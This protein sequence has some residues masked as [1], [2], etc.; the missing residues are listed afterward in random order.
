MKSVQSMGVGAYI[1]IIFIER[2]SSADKY[3][4]SLKRLMD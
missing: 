1:K 3:V 4:D 2:G